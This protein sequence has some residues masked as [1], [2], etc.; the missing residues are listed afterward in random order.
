MALTLVFWTAV[1]MGTVVALGTVL[2]PR[3]TAPIFEDTRGV[4]VPSRVIRLLRYG[5]IGGGIV[6]TVGFLLLATAEWFRIG[7]LGLVGIAGIVIGGPVFSV[8]IGA[9]IALVLRVRVV[10]RNEERQRRSPAE[11]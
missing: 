4:R 9:S 6:A 8:A 3:V 2:G 7:E 1:I 10:E 11:K 5:T